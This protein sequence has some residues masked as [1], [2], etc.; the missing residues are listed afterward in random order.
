MKDGKCCVICKVV[1]L[2]AAIGALNWGLLEFAQLNLVEKVA[3]SGTLAAKVIYG[4]IAVAGLITL[5]K[6]FGFCCPCCK[7]EGTCAK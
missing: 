7:K 4:L 2:L 3:P 1:T 6:V 5:V